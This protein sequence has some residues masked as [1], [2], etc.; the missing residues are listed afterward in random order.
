MNLEPRRDIF[1]LKQ[2]KDHSDYGMRDHWDM[3]DGVE[4]TF[5]LEAHRHAWH[6]PIEIQ[7]RQCT[8]LNKIVGIKTGTDSID[9]ES[10]A[11]NS[12]NLI[13]AIMLYYSIY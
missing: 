11:F 4:G 7:A 12:N 8:C 9:V 6:L 1:R 13:R 2:W 3:V 10:I 5:G